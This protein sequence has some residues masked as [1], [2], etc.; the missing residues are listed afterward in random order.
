MGGAG[1]HAG[2][3]HLRLGSSLAGTWGNGRGT[4]LSAGARTCLSS[5]HAHLPRAPRPA[6]RGGDPGGRPTGAEG[7]GQQDRTPC[8]SIRPLTASPHH[9][10][11]RC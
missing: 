2:P 8:E 5:G 1:P 10:D 9:M 3:R 11:L 7:L 4:Q 6:G